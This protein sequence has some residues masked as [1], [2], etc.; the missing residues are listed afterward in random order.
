MIWEKE[1]KDGNFVFSGKWPTSPRDA[2]AGLMVRESYDQMYL[3]QGSKEDCFKLFKIDFPL[4]VK[5]E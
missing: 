4:T 5:T 3:L 1:E 2:Y